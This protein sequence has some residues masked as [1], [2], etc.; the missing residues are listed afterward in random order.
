MNPL[1]PWLSPEQIIAFLVEILP[2]PKDSRRRFATIGD[3]WRRLISDVTS[4][5]KQRA[6]E[7][8]LLFSIG[9]RLFVTV[10]KKSTGTRPLQ[11]DRFRPLPGRDGR[12]QSEWRRAREAR[13]DSRRRSYLPALCGQR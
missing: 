6:D 4:E 11:T 5:R 12:R 13:R 1:L 2:R 9:K 10:G 7:V 3:D 8:K